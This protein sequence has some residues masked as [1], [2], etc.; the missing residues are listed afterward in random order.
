MNQTREKKHKICAEFTS[1]KIEYA[2]TID[3]FTTIQETRTEHNKQYNYQILLVLNSQKETR[4]K[5]EH[6][7]Q[8]LEFLIKSVANTL[9]EDIPKKTPEHQENE[10][11]P[12]IFLP[13]SK[14]PKVA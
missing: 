1:M 7:K 8:S 10:D 5:M 6:H 11:I 2:Q 12:E 13:Q 9:L 14:T 3:S 4:N